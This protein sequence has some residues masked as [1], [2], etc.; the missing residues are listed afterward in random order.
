[1]VPKASRPP[2]RRAP[3]LAIT[4]SKCRSSTPC[5]VFCTKIFPLAMP[6][7]RCCAASRG[8]KQADG[9]DVAGSQ[10]RDCT[11]FA[12]VFA[13]LTGPAADGARAAE[14][15][16]FPPATPERPVVETMHGVTLTDRYRWLENGKDATV[17]AWSRAQHAA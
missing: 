16:F 9:G 1:M 15:A 2:A 6:S 5:I 14:A 10:K 8:R 12:V 11:A 4:A 3:C 7:L 13:A 17:E